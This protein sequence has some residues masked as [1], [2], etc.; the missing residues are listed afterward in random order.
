MSRRPVVRISPGLHERATSMTS[1]AGSDLLVGIDIGTHSSKGVLCRTDGTVVAE[2]RAEH[3][4]VVPRPGW[5]E[6]DA[7]GVWWH[8]CCSLS[9]QLMAHLQHG[10]RVAAVSVSACGPCVVPVDRHGRP[11][12]RGILYRVDSRASEQ[13]K[14]LD[15]KYGQRA[16]ARLSGTR[17]T[18]QS[19]GPKIMWIRDREPEVFAQTAHFLTASGYVVFKL[20]GEYVVDHHLSSYFGPYVDLRHG[21][22]DLR[23]SDGYLKAG[24]LPEIRWSP[25][26]VGVVGPRASEE[27]GLPQG[28][29]VAAGSTDGLMESVAAGV[30]GSGTLVVNY[31]SV[32]NLFAMTKRVA[33]T[34]HLWPTEGLSAGEYVLA[35]GVA[36]GGSI[37]TWFRKQFAREWPQQSTEEIAFAHNALTAEAEASPAGAN[38]LMLL[39][40]FSGEDTPFYD[41]DARG[42]VAGLSLAST[43]GD[44]YRAILEG[45]AFGLR[46]N[47]A[48]F[49][50]AGVQIERVRALGGGASTRLWPQIVSDVTGLA[51]E[52]PAR[53]GGSAFGSAF[54]AGVAAGL[55][56]RDD[57]ERDWIRVAA[58]VE[59]DPRNVAAYD[60]L[61]DRFRRLYPATRRLVHELARGADGQKGQGNRN[62]A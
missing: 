34:D 32:M 22:W 45:T 21:R 3:A 57:L 8:D 26:V 56:E 33:A 6:H 11:L 47:L 44:V 51:Q 20:T 54:L 31:A 28:T 36:T 42:V 40:Y 50:K 9:R 19:V 27:S 55:L 43:R 60:D 41:P 39:P 59:P 13:I 30:L 15:Q 24:Q 46:H 35:G 23:F 62:G 61:Y 14:A 1:P 58:R 10:S 49:R 16:M 37:T 25:E 38:G 4:V 48:E 52:V 2:A 29:P 17:L 53:T 5:M 12:R 7:D 18:S